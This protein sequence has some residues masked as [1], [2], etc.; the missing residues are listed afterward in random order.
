MNY[1]TAAL[2]VLCAI[3]AA[4]LLLSLFQQRPPEVADRSAPP[5]IPDTEC[6]DPKEA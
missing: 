2:C 6:H 4:L 1:L 5:F 3:L